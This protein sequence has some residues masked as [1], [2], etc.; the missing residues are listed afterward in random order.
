MQR[1][2]SARWSPV[3]ATVRGGVSVLARR[4]KGGYYPRG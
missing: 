1:Q 2:L 4:V 3:G